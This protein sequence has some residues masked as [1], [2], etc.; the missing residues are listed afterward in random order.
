MAGATM[1]DEGDNPVALN[2]TPLVDIIFCLC[3]FFLCSFH[4]KQLEGKLDA[5][6]PQGA[7]PRAGHGEVTLEELRVGVRWDAER[8][9]IATRVNDHP[10]ADVRELEA[11]LTQRRE[12]LVAAGVG[13]PPVTIDADPEV[14]WQGVVR[15]TDVCRRARLDR[16][17]FAA[18]AAAIPAS[19]R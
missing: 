19:G 12:H 10:A 4:F 17:E 9:A 14:P 16:I 5:W 3:L 11:L 1:A 7:G 8:A 15:V 18:P 6:L 13:V 2:V